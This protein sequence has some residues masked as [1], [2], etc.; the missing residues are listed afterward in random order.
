MIPKYRAKLRQGTCSTWGKKDGEWLT[1]D[2][3]SRDDPFRALTIF[4]AFLQ[5]DDCSELD[6]TTLGMATLCKD[7][8]GQ[9]RDHRHDPRQDGRE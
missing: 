2:D 9:V 8:N 6:P 3:I 5:S 4:F 1:T 7:R